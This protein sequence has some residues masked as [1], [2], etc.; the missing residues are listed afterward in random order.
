MT[1]CFDTEFIAQDL[2]ADTIES[3]SRGKTTEEAVKAIDAAVFSPFTGEI[4]CVAAWDDQKG[5]GVCL[6]AGAAPDADLP[7][8]FKIIECEDERAVLTAFWDMCRRQTRFATFN[9][10][11]CDVPYLVGRSLVHHVAVHRPLLDVKPWEDTHV[12]LFARLCPRGAQR[13]TFDIVCRGL[14]IPSPKTEISGSEVGKAWR[15]GR[16]GLVARYC[17]HDVGAVV[18][19]LARWDRLVMGKR[20]QMTMGGAP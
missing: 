11:A 19:C 6:T 10:I 7:H 20:E 14:N 1:L 3:L 16:R 5:L 15:D 2:D 9:G 4:V 13:A 8:G 12:D 17:C 18:E